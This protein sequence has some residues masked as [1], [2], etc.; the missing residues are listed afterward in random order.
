MRIE[1]TSDIAEVKKNN[2]S[3]KIPAKK[4]G[5]V[6]TVTAAKTA[7]GQITT[8]LWGNNSSSSLSTSSNSSTSSNYMYGNSTYYGTPSY[9]NNVGYNGYNSYNY[10]PYYSSNSTNPTGAFSPANPTWEM[11]KKTNV[12]YVYSA[13]GSGYWYTYNNNGNGNVVYTPVS[14]YSNNSGYFT[15]SYPELTTM[16]GSYYTTSPTSTFSSYYNGVYQYGN[17]TSYNSV[18]PPSQVPS[19]CS[20]WNF[21]TSTGRYEW[22]CNGNVWG[23]LKQYDLYLKNLKQNGTRPELIATVCNQGDAMR[24]NYQI[25]IR[26]NNGISNN[27]TTAY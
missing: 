12:V 23:G 1:V 13:P 3:I 9:T 14:N 17:N 15:N 22:Y 27:S 26:V 20:Q 11:Q 18:T 19:G 21:N 8:D 6:Y 24:E 16:N 5:A 2:N 10:N 4:S 25:A 7:K